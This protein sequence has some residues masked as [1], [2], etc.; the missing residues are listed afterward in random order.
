MDMTID[1]ELHVRT[2]SGELLT[3]HIP[4]LTCNVEVVDG[5]VIVDRIW[6]DGRPWPQRGGD[7]D[8]VE[9]ELVRRIKA[10]IAA[11]WDG[12]I[13]D[14]WSEDRDE[15]RLAAQHEASAFQRS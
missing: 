12:H 2:R 14:K 3:V 15:R 5:R 7:V 4:G 11:G 13:R 8:P 10:A 6:I 9:A 1:D